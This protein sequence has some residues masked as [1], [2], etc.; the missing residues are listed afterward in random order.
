MAKQLPKSINLLESSGQPLS[1]WDKIYD[2][3][4]KIGRYVIV[5]VEAVVIMAFVSRFI[6]DRENNDLKDSLD[7][8]ANILQGKREFEAKSRQVQK[9]LTG[10]S[11]IEEN[12]KKT[13][14]KLDDVL[15]NVPSKVSII[16]IS[17]NTQGAS[18]ECIAPDYETVNRMERDFRNDS[19]YTDV[20]IVLSKSGDEDSE[21][22]FSF[23]VKF[24]SEV[25]EE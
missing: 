8:K 1:T 14:D 17:L 19:K 18:M 13:S 12:Q 4:F 16:S 23:N 7:A 3:V 5:V 24:S 15:K 9:V 10:I 11:Q 2:W 22:E 25:E 20:Q 6:L 21:V